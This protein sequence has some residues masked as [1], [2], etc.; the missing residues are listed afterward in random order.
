LK[1]LLAALA[2]A[3]LPAPGQPGLA[4]DAYITLYTQFQQEPPP[5]V[6]S[7][8]Q[9]ELAKIMS[10]IGLRFEWAHLAASRGRVSVDL[11]VVG[12]RGRCDASDLAL[13]VSGPLALGWTQVSDGIVLPFSNID[14]DGIRAFVRFRLV[15]MAK[16]SRDEAYGR[17]VARVLAHELYHVF[18]NTRQHASH[19]VGRAS[20][21]A[22]D[23]L[24]PIFRFEEQPSLALRVAARP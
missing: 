15:H 10:P 11:A 18:A 9:G 3:A 20:Y 21:T 4:R 7:A 24:S 6:L 1:L 8:I 16:T 17:A 2:L 23:L 14:C 22:E 13:S 19:G 12:F 5:V